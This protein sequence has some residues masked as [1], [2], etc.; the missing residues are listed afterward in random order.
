M[1]A[2]VGHRLPLEQ[3]QPSLRR[4][5]R[6]FAEGEPETGSDHG[7]EEY[8]CDETIEADA[9]GFRRRDFRVPGECADGE[10]SREQNRCRQDQE[11]R[12]RQ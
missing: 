4:Q 12:V 1:L 9:G 7:A 11:Y 10:Y 5:R 6:V 3:F 2:R 8:R